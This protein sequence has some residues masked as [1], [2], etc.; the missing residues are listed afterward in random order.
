MDW[1]LNIDLKKLSP[2][3]AYRDTIM[4]TG[5]CFTEHIGNALSDLKFSICQNPNGIL[6]GP[7]AVCKSLISYVENKQF[8][9]ADLFQ[10]NE[11]WS[12]WQHHSRFSH[13]NREEAVRIIN[14]SQQQAHEFL[15]KADW[16]IITLGSSFSYKLTGLS[17]KAS[18]STGGGVANCH[19]A[20][21]QWFDKQ[22]LEIPEIIDLLENCLEKL[23]AF[24]NKLNIIFT[25]SPVRHIRDGVVENNRSKA[26]LIES[27]HHMVQKYG[28]AHYFPAY[29]LVI[30]VLRDYRFYDIDLVHPNYPATEF[31]LEKFAESC[32]DEES[33]QLMQEVKKIVIARKHKPFQPE[34]KAHQQFLINHFEK[35]KALQKKFPFLDLKEE[36]VYFSET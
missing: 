32:I 13:T 27:V 6:F 25:V 12:S 17:D 21:A 35:A 20:P 31:V 33:Q 24:N 36:L 23:S 18:C 15:K 1:M 4:L 7:D 14:Q 30:D 3:V 11:V 26:R 28:Q 5:S 22:M 8:T 2:P 34:T 9:E 10:L 19:R 16:L 29:E